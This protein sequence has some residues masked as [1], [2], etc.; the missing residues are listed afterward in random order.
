M[1]N[2]IPLRILHFDMKGLL[3]RA[4]F[5]IKLLPEIAAMG[6][7]ALL[8]EFEDKFPYQ[9]LPEIVHPDAWNREELSAFRDQAEKCN[10]EIIPLLQCAGHL[11][12]ILK[13]EKYRHLRE[14]DPPRDSTNEWCLHDASEPFNI[15]QSMAGELLGFF[16]H[17]R[18]FHIGADEYK[19]SLTCSRCGDSDRFEQFLD[20]VLNC[21]ELIK[22]AGRKVVVWDDMF[23]NHE[24]DKLNLLLR[25]VVPCVWQYI[26]VNEDFVQRMCSISPEVWGASKIQN[27][28]RYRGLGAQDAVMVNVDDWADVAQ[29]Y[30]LTGLV[31]T[32]W[33]RNHGLS[34]LAQTL[35]ESFY[36]LGYQGRTL[37]HG[38]ITDRTAFRKEFAQKFFALEDMPWVDEFYYR[39]ELAEKLLN[40]AVPQ[41]ARNR[42]ILKIWQCFNAIDVFWIYCDMC[43][44]SNMALYN[45]YISNLAPDDM[46]FNFR[47]G[48][49]ITSERIDELKKRFREQTGQLF[50]PQLLEEY[51]SSRL[52]GVL[53]VNTFWSRIIEDAITG[54]KL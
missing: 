46:T 24:S 29:K 21:T 1:N 22:N 48:V 37:T 26:G 50:T 51:L 8:V 40:E 30:A 14:G 36:M 53:A 3:P 47:D 43:F 41:A 23:R 10:I 4:D 54:K 52:D 42:D 34:P 16:P 9:L 31:A 39:P 32:I 18:Y 11:D 20:H 17:A 44:G 27:D 12:Y 5:M 25:Q 2:I 49:R 7:N 35:P 6:Y 19:C 15:F 45:S 13:H 38:K 33:G 28:P